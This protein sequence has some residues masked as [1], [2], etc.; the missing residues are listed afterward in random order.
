MMQGL[1]IKVEGY[2]LNVKAG[3]VTLRFCKKRKYFFFYFHITLLQHQSYQFV[4]ESI[5]IQ[6]IWIK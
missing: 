2:N 1:L 4:A 6:H 5:I 3:I